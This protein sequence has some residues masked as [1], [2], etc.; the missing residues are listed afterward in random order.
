[1]EID[2]HLE[3]RIDESS[4]DLLQSTFLETEISDQA[5]KRPPS[6]PIASEY[7]SKAQ[8]I[9]KEIR[10]ADFANTKNSETGNSYFAIETAIDALQAIP[11]I[12]EE[13]LLDG[14]DLFEDERKAETFLALDAT[15]RKKWLLRK[16]GRS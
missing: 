16:L 14:C 15:L 4:G 2:Q 11:D 6:T 10:H 13:V 3:M 9:S 5:R 7:R 1:M 8:K 12:D